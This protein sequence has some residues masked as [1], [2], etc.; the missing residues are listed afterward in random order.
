MKKNV[1]LT[2]VLVIGIMSIAGLSFAMSKSH[3]AQNSSS[4]GS[5][6]SSGGANQLVEKV[7]TKV[8]SN[9]RATLIDGLPNVLGQLV[10]E[11]DQVDVLLTFDAVLK[12]GNKEH[13]TVTLLQNV[14]VLTSGVQRMQTALADAE[15]T[16]YNGYV[17]LALS[18]R[19]AQYLALSRSE[20]VL[21]IVVRSPGD[22]TNYLMEIAT[23]D[24]LFQ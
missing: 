21:D 7:S 8:P 6:A 18:P 13:A 17:V 4:S 5:G 1:F 12:S 9:M 22:Q 20:G 24:K 11:G 10:A 2:I 19:D 23:F 15:K 14:K 16:K 3:Q